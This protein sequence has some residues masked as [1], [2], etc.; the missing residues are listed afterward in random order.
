M[1]FSLGYRT[2]V[3][4][5]CGNP[6]TEVEIQTHQNSNDLAR[7]Y[8]GVCSLHNCSPVFCGGNYEGLLRSPVKPFQGG[9]ACV[10]LGNRVPGYCLEVK[11]WLWY[12]KYI[13]MAQGKFQ[14]LLLWKTAKQKK[15]AALPQ[16]GQA[17]SW[18]KRLCPNVLLLCSQTDPFQFVI[19]TNLIFACYLNRLKVFFSKKDYFKYRFPRLLN[20]IDMQHTYEIFSTIK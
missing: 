2:D 3:L 19:V 15:Y 8:I 12:L 20:L 11:I 6:K 17:F 4:K 1:Q 13:K 10:Y 5:K 14:L 18:G 7:W 16:L 9:F